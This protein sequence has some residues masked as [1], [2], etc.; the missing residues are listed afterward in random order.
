LLI[1]IVF[2]FLLV[3]LLPFFIRQVEQNLEVF[4]LLMGLLAAAISGML[5]L[6]AVTEIFKNSLL[7]MITAAVLISGMLFKLLRPRIKLGIEGILRFIPLQV[8]ICL[9]IIM[10]GLFSSL[11]TAIIA[12]LVLVEIV[13]ILPLARPEKIKVNI[14]ACFAIGLG[15]VLTPLGEPLS[16]IVI[17][18]LNQHFWYL[19]QQVGMFI[20]PGIIAM[21]ILG[22]L[23]IRKGALLPDLQDSEEE[24]VE[25]YTDVIV[26]ALKV[27]IFVVALEFLGAGFKP[28]VDAYVVFL[29]SR[30]LYPLNMI[31]AILDNATLAA[32]EV[33]LKMGKAQL[34]AILMGLLISGGMLIPGN[35]PNIISAGKLKI[36]SSEWARLGMPLG[37]ALMLIYYL[38][39]FVI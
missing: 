19:Y 18:R 10:L 11:I 33:S 39:L 23:T 13:H 32:A 14:I 35:I 24:V 34:V 28:L 15:A 4:L 27:F 29:D 9:V 16:T 31:S 5:N 21:G 30:I 8:F 2:V 17:S 36:R 1:G 22:G 25:T 26:R 7:Y 20:I 6:G 37:G 12:S 38:I 3:L